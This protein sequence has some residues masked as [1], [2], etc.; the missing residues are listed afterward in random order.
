MD[1]HLFSV[2]KIPFLLILC[3]GNMGSG[4]FFKK[5]YTQRNQN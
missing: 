4:F 5:M 2:W 3:E 1:I